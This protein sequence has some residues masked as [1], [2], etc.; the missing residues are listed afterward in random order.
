MCCGLTVAELVQ[1]W[2]NNPGAVVALLAEHGS[3]VVRARTAA[4]ITLRWGLVDGVECLR[5]LHERVLLLD[6]NLIIRATP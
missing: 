6:E 1:L 5:Q 3:V 4:T 2:A